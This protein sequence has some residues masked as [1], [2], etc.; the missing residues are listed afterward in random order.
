MSRSRR[1][2]FPERVV[3]QGPHIGEPSAAHPTRQHPLGGRVVHGDEALATV[4]TPALPAPRVVRG[5]AAVVPRV[6]A[7]QRLDAATAAHQLGD[8]AHCPRVLEV[9][10]DQRAVGRSAVQAV[11]TEAVQVVRRHAHVHVRDWLQRDGLQAR[12]PVPQR[13]VLVGRQA[14]ISGSSKRQHRW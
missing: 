2:C 3:A 11:V 5:W 9:V 6:E 4:G 10:D 8:V 13:R 1:R 12:Q 14:R 7:R